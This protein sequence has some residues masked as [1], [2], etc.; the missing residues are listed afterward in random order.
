[1]AKDKDGGRYKGKAT[2]K[3][4]GSQLSQRELDELTGRG[5]GGSGHT[6]QVTHTARS[7]RRQ[8]RQNR[9][10]GRGW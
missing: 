2:P 4:L 10:D 7:Q 3:K 9:K 1:M 6:D 8:G 5:K